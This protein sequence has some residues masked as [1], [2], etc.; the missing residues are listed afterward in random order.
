MSSTQFAVP[1]SR[2]PRATGVV[3]P[4]PA[5]GP[6]RLAPRWHERGGE[7]A[8]QHA[9]WSFPAVI[10]VGDCMI[11]YKMDSG[12]RAVD[13]LCWTRGQWTRAALACAHVCVD[14]HRCVPLCHAGGQCHSTRS[15]CSS[16][17][18]TFQ[19]NVPPLQ[20]FIHSCAWSCTATPHRYA[21]A[22]V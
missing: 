4:T 2:W 13:K 6:P 18:Q 3:P 15:T 22:I 9:G 5:P 14:R 12:R 1:R 21:T 7:T 11:K 19:Q 20:V 8:V 16:L 10:M 17:P